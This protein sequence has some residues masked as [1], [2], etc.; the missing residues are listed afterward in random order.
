VARDIPEVQVSTIGEFG[1]AVTDLS[2]TGSLG[3]LWYRGLGQRSFSL[4]PSLYRNP[5]TALDLFEKEERMV[6]AFRAR[7]RPFMDS[8]LEGP[9]VSSSGWQHLFMMQHYGAPTR[10]LDWSENAFV[11]LYF[12]ITA[13]AHGGYTSDAV[14]CLLDPAGWNV[15]VVPRMLTPGEALYEGSAA[16]TS[17]APG[18]DPDTM[19]Q[20]IIS[21]YAAFNNP[22]ITA[23]RGVFSVFGLDPRSMEE[24]HAG[25]ADG[26]PLLQKIVLPQSALPG[27]RDDLDRLGFRESMI[28]PGLAEFASETRRLHGL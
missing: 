22:R 16:L 17:Y 10:L 15:E 25:F 23:Q 28:Y 24:V 9:G 26:D 11:A 6:A 5:G 20:G 13:A 4:V 2:R 27:L 7:S 12:A 19:G 18:S 14:V 8:P 1:D 3:F 21:M